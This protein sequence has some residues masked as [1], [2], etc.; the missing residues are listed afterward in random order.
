MEGLNKIVDDPALGELAVLRG[1]Y[2]G[3]QLGVVIM[4]AFIFEDH[5]LLDPDRHEEFMRCLYARLVMIGASGLFIFAAHTFFDIED[6]A[7]MAATQRG[8]VE[9]IR[10][11]S[12]C[13]LIVMQIVGLGTIYIGHVIN[14]SQSNYF[15]GVIMVFIGVAIMVPIS[16]RLLVI[17]M[18]IM[19]SAHA[20]SICW[21][22][23]RLVPSTIALSNLSMLVGGAAVSWYGSHTMHRLRAQRKVAGA[24]S[25]PTP[26]EEEKPSRF[27]RNT[28]AL[29]RVFI[30]V[31][32]SVVSIQARVNIYNNEVADK[33]ISLPAITM[34]GEVGATDASIQFRNSTRFAISL[35]N[36][37]VI[38]PI[39]QALILD[40]KTDDEKNIEVIP[41]DHTVR[42]YL[43]DTTR[44]YYLDKS[45]QINKSIKGCFPNLIRL[46]GFRVN[47]VT[48]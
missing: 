2:R 17:N 48:K 35:E 9:A 31:V 39:G 23:H 19:I 16:P 42:I 22:E 10:L 5:A 21:D 4:I 15:A 44:K 8:K 46:V 34:I 25:I 40:V 32:F 41:P 1:L 18:F 6:G 28:V 47:S 45:D 7:E 24:E 36:A 13:G 26:L 3:I 27:S 43:S 33:N 37:Q 12:I 14:G 11:Y 20:L 30:G 38:F 29:I